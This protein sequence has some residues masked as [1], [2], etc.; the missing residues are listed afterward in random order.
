MDESDYLSVLERRLE[1]KNRD[2]PMDIICEFKKLESIIRK[3]EAFE[4]YNSGKSKEEIIK[5]LDNEVN[6]ELL[7]HKEEELSNYESKQIFK[8]IES[9]GY[10]FEINEKQREVIKEEYP[11]IDEKVDFFKSAILSDYFGN[12]VEYS[13]T[14]N[15]IIVLPS[16]NLESQKIYML[17]CSALNAAKIRKEADYESL[18]NSGLLKHINKF[19][20]EFNPDY[21]SKEFVDLEINELRGTLSE[22]YGVSNQISERLR[23]DTFNFIIYSVL[24]IVEED[25]MKERYNSILKTLHINKEYHKKWNESLKKISKSLTKNETFSDLSKIKNDGLIGN[26]I[27]LRSLLEINYEGNRIS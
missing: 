15:K 21:Q 6:L 9:L 3:K 26:Y 20:T 1:E 19:Y 27:R 22:M 24:N 23:L 2:R 10:S 11:E 14:L 8:D 7:K 18:K 4:A 17:Y 25:D 12:N 5:V 13:P 16:N